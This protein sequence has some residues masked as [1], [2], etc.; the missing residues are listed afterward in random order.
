MVEAGIV[1]DD[2]IFTFEKIV[3]Y[4]FVVRE[5]NMALGIIY[6]VRSRQ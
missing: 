4:F 6:L 3:L 2:E 1:S 5:L